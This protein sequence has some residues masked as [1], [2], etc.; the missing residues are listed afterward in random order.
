MKKTV[1]FEFPDDFQFPEHFEEINPARCRIC[2]LHCNDEGRS[3]W[4]LLTGDNDG[5]PISDRV[6]CPFHDESDNVNCCM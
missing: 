4:C 1:V 3:E 6:K 5:T 2:P